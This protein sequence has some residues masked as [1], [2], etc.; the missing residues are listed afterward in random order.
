MEVV[1]KCPEV[2]L[3]DHVTILFLI[4]APL[5]IAALFTVAKRLEQLKCPSVGGWINK[6][7][8]RQTMEYYSAIRRKEILAHAIT[9]INFE[10]IMVSEISQS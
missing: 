9:W 7:G 2:G 6:I 4:F 8:Y 10:G 3:L 5:F 1:Q